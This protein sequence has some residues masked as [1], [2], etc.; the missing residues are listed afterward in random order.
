MSVTD[1]RI[2]THDDAQS[3]LTKQTD[4][5]NSID[6]LTTAVGNQTT[7]MVDR[8]NNQSIDGVKTFS[9]APVITEVIPE[10]DDST[11]AATTSWIESVFFN[12]LVAKLAASTAA[13]ISSLNTSSLFYRMLSW[14]LT[15]AG[16]Q[17]NITN[18]N[19]WYICLGALFGGLIIQ[20]GKVNFSSTTDANPTLVQIPIAF[21]T[22][23]IAVVA[24]GVYSSGNAVFTTIMIDD[25][26]T[27][28]TQVAGF[29][30]GANGWTWYVAFGS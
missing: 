25:N 15:A 2:F 9:S 11:K 7:N 29:H 28:N 13:S 17:Y 18:A 21:T 12:K 30:S 16:V 19:A 22:N 1:D 14:A 27:T 20:G 6:A 24:T 23:R 26:K 8:S 4:I 10:S 5:K 3:L